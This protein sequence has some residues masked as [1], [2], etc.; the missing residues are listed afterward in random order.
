MTLRVVFGIGVLV[1]MWEVLAYNL[2]DG[3]VGH[4]VMSQSDAITLRGEVKICRSLPLL[5]AS[6]CCG[7]T[8][9]CRQL[10]RFNDP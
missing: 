4:F 7:V 10:K 1:V 9:F 2:G 3:I 6:G 5:A 8:A